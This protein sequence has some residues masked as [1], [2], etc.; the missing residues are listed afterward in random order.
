LLPHIEQGN[1]AQQI[2]FNLPVEDPSNLAARTTIVKPYVCP[3]DR[4][5]GLF[6]IYDKNNTP[7][8]QAAT[9]SYAACHGIG[10][11]LDEELD[12]FNG[13]FSRNSRVR[14]ADVTD[15]TSSTIAIGERGSF[16]TQTPWAG[17]VSFGTT[18]ITPGAPTN[19]A[20]AIEDAPTQT[21]VHVAVHTVNDP[22]SDPEDF[23]APHTGTAN[24]LFVDGSVR[25]VR[26]GISISVLQALATRNGGE[27]VNPDD[28]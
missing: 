14:F 3:S 27:V 2:N 11:D 13:M 5:T 23:F 4:S 24:F 12:D 26:T 25:P 28:Y 21:L 1:L 20:T 19:N 22:N 6:T 9:N 16:F 15:G 18:R 17:A 8:A 10:V 7:L